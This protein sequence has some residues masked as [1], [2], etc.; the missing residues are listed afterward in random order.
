MFYFQLNQKYDISSF[1]VNC[2]SH[3]FVG[4]VSMKDGGG[5]G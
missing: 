2:P 1:P 5:G 3:S 4:T